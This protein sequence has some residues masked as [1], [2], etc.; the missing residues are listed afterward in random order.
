MSSEFPLEGRVAKG[1]DPTIGRNLP[2][3]KA[4]G[5]GGDTDHWFIQRLAAH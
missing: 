4:V 1:E 3:A 2:V 5:R